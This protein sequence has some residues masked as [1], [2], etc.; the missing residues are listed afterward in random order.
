MVIFGGFANGECF[1]DVHILHLPTG[2]WKEIA[3]TGDVPTP[4]TSHSAVCD[5]DYLL[6]FGGTSA[7]F[8]V[9]NSNKLHLLDIA[10]GK[11]AEIAPAGDVPAP[12]Y[13]QSMVL[14][15]GTM[16]VYIFGGTTGQNFFDDLFCFDAVSSVWHKIEPKGPN[17][18]SA[19]YRH[20]AVSTDTHMFIVG[21]GNNQPLDPAGTLSVWSFEYAT[22]QWTE[23]ATKTEG[24]YPPPVPRLHHTSALRDGHLYVHGGTNGRDIYGEWLWRL[25]LSTMTWTRLPTPTQATQ[26]FF[27][28]A[29]ITASG[30]Y[31]AF[32]GCLDRSGP[33]G[34]AQTRSA[35]LDSKWLDVPSLFER[36]LLALGESR[37]LTKN[38]FEQDHL[39]FLE[40]MIID[41]VAA[42]PA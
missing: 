1:N 40:P 3:T 5:G 21:G 33:H 41:H 42:L 22:Q 7:D 36:C 32:G 16:E 30:R 34:V 6:V 9:H 38:T 24:K 14:R 27:H 2:N 10:E 37:M 20:T 11:W 26:L 25:D 29:V 17:M 8:G 35:R 13:G 39:R 15:P 31:V 12:R 19:R 23:H 18:P 28:S 4:I